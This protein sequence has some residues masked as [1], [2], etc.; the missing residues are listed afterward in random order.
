MLILFLLFLIQFSIACACLAVNAKQQE[1]LAEQVF[2]FLHNIISCS[3]SWLLSYTCIIFKGWRRVGDDLRAKV[4]ETF[5]CCGF[6]DTVIEK[7]PLACH[8]KNVSIL[9][10]WAKS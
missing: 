5:H 7:D 1:Q 2:L 9:M 6:N 3:N 8:D 4:E 10:N